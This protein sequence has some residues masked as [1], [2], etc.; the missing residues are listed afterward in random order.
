MYAGIVGLLSLTASE[1]PAASS[2]L[3]ARAFDFAIVFGMLSGAHWALA[4]ARRLFAPEA[5]SLLVVKAFCLALVALAIGLAL[6][7]GRW[8]PMVGELG[9]PGLVLIV[10]WLILTQAVSKA[11]EA[12]RPR[13]VDAT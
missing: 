11:L 4:A 6:T 2:S 8:G 3:I 10:A 1:E 5:R 12:R 7:G 13:S 9:A